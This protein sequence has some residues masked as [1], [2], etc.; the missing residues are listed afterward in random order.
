[1]RAN[2]VRAPPMGITVLA[3]LLV[4]VAVMA[5]KTVRGM[6]VCPFCGGEIKRAGEKMRCLACD[7]LFFMWQAKRR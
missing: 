2:M 3:I 5:I 6:F 1:M 4:A 7:R